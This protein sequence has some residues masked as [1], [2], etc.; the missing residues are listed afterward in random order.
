MKIMNNNNKKK[1]FENIGF[2]SNIRT[3]DDVSSSSNFIYYK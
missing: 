2:D 1:M 3:F